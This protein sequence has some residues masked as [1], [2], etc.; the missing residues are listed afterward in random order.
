MTYATAYSTDEPP[1]KG[2]TTT[3]A[4]A[5]TGKKPAAA[6]TNLAS[7]KAA[8]ALKKKR[9]VSLLPFPSRSHVR[10]SVYAVWTMADKI[11]DPDIR[12]TEYPSARISRYTTR[13]LST[14]RKSWA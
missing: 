8:L 6:A 7:K 11:V 4:G 10:M 14:T 5:S 1:T 3:V 13:K 9:Q 12:D 2:K